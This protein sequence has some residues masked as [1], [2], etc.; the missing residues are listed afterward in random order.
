MPDFCFDCKCPIDMTP[1]GEFCLVPVTEHGEPMT[2]DCGNLFLT[3]LCPSCGHA[4][5]AKTIAELVGIGKATIEDKP[6]A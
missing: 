5:S 4:R 3:A 2:D 6:N 1:R